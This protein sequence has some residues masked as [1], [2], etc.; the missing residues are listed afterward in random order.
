MRYLWAGHA[1]ITVGTE[2]LGG[3]RAG[4]HVCSPRLTS[5][6]TPAGGQTGP[7]PWPWRL[8]HPDTCTRMG[9][10]QTAAGR[11]QVIPSVW[12]RVSTAKGQ[13]W[14]SGLQSPPSEP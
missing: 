2:G 7:G 8:T 14:G 9:R 10:T 13:A 1:C 6:S 11:W 5:G 4:Q 12:A 3:D